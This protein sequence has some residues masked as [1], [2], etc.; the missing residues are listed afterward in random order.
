MVSHV[1]DFAY[2]SYFLLPISDKLASSLA[3]RTQSV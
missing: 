3:Q 1:S 2:Q